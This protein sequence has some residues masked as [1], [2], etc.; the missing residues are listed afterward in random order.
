MLIVFTISN[1]GAFLTL[2]SIFYQA[3]V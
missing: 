3:L 2:M 1:E